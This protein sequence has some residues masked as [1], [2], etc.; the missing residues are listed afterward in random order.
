MA[1]AP[2]EHDYLFKILLL[3]DSGVGKSNLLLRYVDDIYKSDLGATIGVDFKICSRMIDDKLVKMQIWD[4]AGQERF[5]TITI[6]YYRGS[7]GILVVYDVTDRNSF[8]HVRSWMQEIQKYTDEGA[9]VIL[10][11]NKVDLHSKRVVTSDEGAE[12]AEE[13]GIRFI[14]TSARNA[15]N[16]E[17]MFEWLARDITARVQPQVQPQRLRVSLGRQCAEARLNGNLQSCTG[18]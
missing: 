6:S 13:L 18:C 3:G 2:R 4:T 1:G 16:I 15:H 10:V 11:G 12:L 7:H 5:R 17:H 14:E 8:E 9:N